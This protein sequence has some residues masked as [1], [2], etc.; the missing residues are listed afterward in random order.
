[1]SQ[2]RRGK[3]WCV[4]VHIGKESKEKEKGRNSS[5]ISAS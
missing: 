2:G 1:M 4:T 3:E 5:A